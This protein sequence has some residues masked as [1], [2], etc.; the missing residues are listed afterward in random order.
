MNAVTLKRIVVLGALTGMRSM[1]GL[2]CS[3][4]GI[5]AWQAR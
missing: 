2:A 5:R 3:L 1:A 4:G